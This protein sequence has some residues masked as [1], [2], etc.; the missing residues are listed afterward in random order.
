MTL[1][2]A[3]IWLACFLVLGW[4]LL[5]APWSAFISRN[6]IFGSSFFFASYNRKYRRIFAMCIGIAAVT[7]VIFN[8]LWLNG[9]VKRRLW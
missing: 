1:V 4:A 6:Y 2:F 9:M 8:V 3:S 7:V 5:M